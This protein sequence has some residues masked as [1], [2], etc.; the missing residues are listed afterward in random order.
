[1]DMTLMSECIF[2]RTVTAQRYE[3]YAPFTAKD[4]SKRRTLTAIDTLERSESRGSYSSAIKNARDE[5]S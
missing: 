2:V 5:Y 4:L 3:D 1:M